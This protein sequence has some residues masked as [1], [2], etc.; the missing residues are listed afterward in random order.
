MRSELNERFPGAYQLARIFGWLDDYTWFKTEITY[1]EAYA[2][3]YECKTISEFKKKY[4][5]YYEYFKRNK[6]THKLPLEGK[7]IRIT[8]KICRERA[9]QCKTRSEFKKKHNATWQYALD[10]NLMDELFGPNSHSLLNSY[11][12]E[13]INKCIEKAKHF[14]CITHFR[15]ECAFESRYL[16][17][18]AEDIL[19]EIFPKREVIEVIKENCY[20]YGSMC[21]SK[22]E[23]HNTYRQLYEY[24]KE[25]NFIDDIPFNSYKDK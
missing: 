16:E 5:R 21:K 12:Q 11:D 4:K 19:Y 23:F 9:Q 22:T 8:E 10:H 14:S 20:K 6:I 25:N 13:I 3:A 24:S 17:R 15:K 7:R 1:E 18:Y 2:A